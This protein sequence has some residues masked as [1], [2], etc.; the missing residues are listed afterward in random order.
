RRRDR[1]RRSAPTP[2][3]R[4]PPPRPIPPPP[5][6]R[7]AGVCDSSPARRARRP[8]RPTRIQPLARRAGSAASASWIDA[9]A[10]AADLIDGPLRPRDPAFRGCERAPADLR[11]R[12]ERLALDAMQDERHALVDGHAVEHLVPRAEQQPIERIRPGVD[13]R[14]RRW[15]LLAD[16]QPPP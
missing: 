8:G 2:R 6:P 1:A 12:V 14:R 7:D 16:P 3:S 13:Q 10:V 5:P 9:P 4:P 15:T 11:H